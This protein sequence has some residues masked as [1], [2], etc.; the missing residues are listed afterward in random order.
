MQPWPVSV[1][2]ILGEHG[3]SF[4]VAGKLA[5]DR[6]VVGDEEF[7]FREPADV[8]VDITNTGSGIVA[9][10]HISAPVTATCS[11]CL[12]DFPMTIEAEV[13]GFYVEPG[14]DEGI[15]E[16]QEVELVRRDETIDLAPALLEALTLEAPF[17][18][19]HAE[20]CAGIC[21]GCGQDLNEGSCSCAKPPRPEHPFAVL[22]DLLP[23][24]SDDDSDAPR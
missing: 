22:A 7:Y 6:L 14:H 4:E 15:P 1:A 11:R 13:D 3:A 23:T 8:R 16:E 2:E 21:P 20:D 17:V 12:C 24:P 10:G 9:M 18:P 5:M 19:L